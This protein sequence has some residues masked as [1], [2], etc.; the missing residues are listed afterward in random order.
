MK[1]IVFGGAGYIGSHLVRELIRTTGHS[2]IIADNLSAAHGTKPPMDSKAQFEEGDVRDEAFLERIFETHKPDAVVHMC[3]SIVVPES[4]RD[5]LMYY[6][7]NVVGSL[8]I[9]QA[10][11]KHN[12]KYIVFSSTAALFGTPKGDKAGQPIG[13]S[14]PT[15]PESPYGDTKLVT[16]WMLK[17]VDVAHGIKHVC[18]RYFN[19]CGAHEDGDIGEAH[20]PE[21]HLIPIVLQVPLG[22]RQKISIFGN[23]FATKDGTCVRDYIHVSDLA[24]AHIKALEYLEKKGESASFNLGVGEGYSVKEVV[25]AARK[26]TGHAIPEESCPRREGDPPSLVADPTRAHEVLGWKARYG[27]EEIIATAWKFHQAHPNGL[28]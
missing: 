24:S 27:L 8:R 18:L 11:Q 19:A 13:P 12:C 28:H 15:V 3:A 14:D 5:P 6:D 25:E 2:V 1:I 9:L 23:D 7:N 16:E 4:V 10:M 20:D 21:T 26:V 17:S 22:K